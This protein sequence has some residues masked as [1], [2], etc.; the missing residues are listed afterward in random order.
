MKAQSYSWK[1]HH[2]TKLHRIFTQ[3][4]KSFVNYILI[5]NEQPN[6]IGTFN[7]YASDIQITKSNKPLTILIPCLL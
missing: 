5:G 1:K 3:N 4:L 7:S 2:A 6:D